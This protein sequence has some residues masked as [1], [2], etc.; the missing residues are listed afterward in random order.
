M[1]FSTPHHFGIT[2]TLEIRIMAAC[3]EITT[4]WWGVN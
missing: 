1:D 4:K 3:L 2:H